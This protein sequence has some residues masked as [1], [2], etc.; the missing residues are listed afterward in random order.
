MPCPTGAIFADGLL[1]TRHAL[2]SSNV[3]ALPFFAAKRFH[4]LTD[5]IAGIW[6]LEPAF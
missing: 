6:T 3:S 4:G 1:V 2:T 5:A